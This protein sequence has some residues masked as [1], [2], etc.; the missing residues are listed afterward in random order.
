[1]KRVI[2]S[3]MCL[4][5]VLV[6]VEASNDRPIVFEQLPTQSQQ[7]IKNYFSG[8]SIA[9]VKMESDFLYK[10][11][12][13]IFTN[14][15]K[16]EFDKSGAWKEVGCKYSSLPPGVIPVA[17]RNYVSANYP[18]VDVRKIE[19]KSRGRYEM[20]LANGLDLTFDSKF[21]LIDVDH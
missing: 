20:E 9:L 4:L 14:G 21:N 8:Q 3:L 16:I 5:A 17:L 10:S 2:I 11:Y 19:K 1:M 12:E 7:F 18:G 13:V 15:D 6:S